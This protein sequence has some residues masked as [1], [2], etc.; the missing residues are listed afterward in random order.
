[1]FI[2]NNWGC[3]V[4]QIFKRG[5]LKIQNYLFL[6]SRCCFN[7]ETLV[8]TTDHSNDVVIIYIY[9]KKLLVKQE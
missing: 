5:G 7:V 6:L 1:M 8:V 2:G 9:I 4:I 3:L